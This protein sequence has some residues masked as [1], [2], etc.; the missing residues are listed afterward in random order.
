MILGADAVLAAAPATPVQLAHACL[1]A[2][3]D[4]AVPV[5]WGDELIAASVLRDLQTRERGPVVQCSCPLAARRL[6]AA[7][8]EL[9]PFLLSAVSPPVAAARYL[10]AVHEGRRLRITYV[11]RC[12]GA[13]DDDIDARVTAEELLAIF[14]DRNVSLAEQ[15]TE[16]DDVI[17]PDRRR[18]R[19]LPGG[20]PRPEM[21]RA[22]SGRELVEVA[23][24][25]LSLQLAQLLLAGG[26]V[27]VDVGPALGCMCAGA[28][29]GSSADAGDARAR[30]VAVEPPLASAPILDESVV[31]SVLDPLPGPAPSRASS[32]L[33]TP[34]PVTPAADL[35]VPPEPPPLA[36]SLTDDAG[37]GV[38]ASGYT[39]TADAAAQG[40]RRRSPAQ[41]V[42]TLASTTP[43]AR[44]ADGRQ[45]PRAYIAHRR[46]SPRGL[47][48][49]GGDL[50]PAA[51]AA[52]TAPSLDQVT[53]TDEAPD[54]ERGQ[55]AT[56]DQPAICN[57][58]APCVECAPREEPVMRDDSA[59]RD[60]PARRSDLAV[61]RTLAADAD[62]SP[63]CA[64]P[65]EPQP[66][67]PPAS[68]PA[69][70]RSS[71]TAEQGEPHTNGESPDIGVVLLSVIGG[72]LDALINRLLP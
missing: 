14:E 36:P 67:A 39:L 26:N 15:P 22:T 27:L 61:L 4:A 57:E 60:E 25:E 56:R 55:T 24:D 21:L 69:P 62:A 43:V 2:G 44:D 17:P 66:A 7:G 68:E 49:L 63:T 13:A 33:A 35:W 52:V 28:C 41:G 45:L 11:G 59:R 18:F 23:G 6:L 30:I 40:P 58:S 32:E 42:R 50:P 34:V 16:F 9:R 51:A 48:A 64:P 46:S 38:T 37:T 71:A 53:C 3:Y 47:R 29:A 72:T 54:S 31:V 8:M 20:V 65:N 70:Q 10:R 19:S 5:S 1:Q 12:P